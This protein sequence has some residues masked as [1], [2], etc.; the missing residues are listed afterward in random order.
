[1]VGAS[2][3]AMNDDAVNLTK[4]HRLRRP[5]QPS[6]HAKHPNC[7]ITSSS[8]LVSTISAISGK[9]MLFVARKIASMNSRLS[10]LLINAPNVG[11][12]DFQ[13][14]QPQLGEV[15]DLAE[16]ATKMLQADAVTGVEQAMAQALQ[17]FW[18]GSWRSSISR[19]SSGASSGSDSSM[20]RILCS[21]A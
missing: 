9:S 8:P 10:L 12:V 13:V 6:H 19:V 17:F 2:L 18:G 4:S 7:L 21:C 14:S 1:M 3:L 20:S 16:A 5:D 11:P 15:A